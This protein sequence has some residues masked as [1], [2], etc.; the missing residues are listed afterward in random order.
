MSS[1]K[2]QS[3]L[4][5]KQFHVQDFININEMSDVGYHDELTQFNT[6]NNLGVKD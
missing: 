2:M 5:H 1:Q 6:C 4:N 3:I